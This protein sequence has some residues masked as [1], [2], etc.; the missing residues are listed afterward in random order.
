MS[1]S[2]FRPLRILE[3]LASH[4]VQF[5][6][7]GG[8][9]TGLY[10]APFS[11]VDVDVVPKLQTS[12]LDRLA[13]ALRELD[14]VLRD[15]EEPEGI[16]IELDGRIL[17]KALPDFQFLRFNTKYG[18]LDLLYQP[19]GTK[20]FRDLTKAAVEMDL[21]SVTVR[22][23]SLADVIRSKEALGRPRDLEQLPT[24]RRLLEI[25][26]ESEE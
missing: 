15:E 13:A 8:V 17:K 14:A 12:N 26:E 22:V 5:I 18:F 3:V 7:I 24:L 10:T 16:A 1:S 23:A 21:E 11:T 4:D 6:L 20:G 9:A 2:E 19:A 25:Q